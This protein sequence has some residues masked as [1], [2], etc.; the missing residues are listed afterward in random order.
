[1]TASAPQRAASVSKQLAHA[2]AT[3][4]LA[5]MP[6]GVVAEAERAV[7]D[8]FGSALAGAIERPALVCRQVVSALGAS[9]EATVFLAGRA[10][11]A[12]AALAN[13]VAAHILELDDI[14]KASTVHAGAPVIAAAFAVAERER[15]ASPD[16]LLA[17]IVGYEAALRVGEAVNPSHYRFWHPT[18]TAAT[19]G[20]AVAAG[21][22]LHLGP[23]RML[24]ALGTAGTQAA[25]LW[26][27]NADGAMSKPLHAGKA[28]FNGVLAADLAA[29]GFSGATRILEGPRGFFAA[30]S[31]TSD[32]TRITDGLGSRWKIRENCYKVHSCCAHTHAAIDLAIELRT[33]HDYPRQDGVG[34]I[35]DVHVETYGPGFAIVNEPDPGTPAR[36]QFSMTYCVAVGLAE[37]EAGLAQFAESRF[38]TSGVRD[39]AVAALMR[40]TRVTVDDGLTRRYPAAWPAR[41]TVTLDD[42][43]VLRGAADFPRGNPER[44]LSTADLEHKFLDLLGGRFGQNRARSALAAARATVGGATVASAI[45]DHAPWAVHSAW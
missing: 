16:F 37:G 43:T 32:P 40:R 14:H 6:D 21:S 20:A 23:D 1:M 18:G 4:R 22:L 34:R 5:D 8:W 3:A 41:L 35:A 24:D 27:F 19:F 33:R 9:N 12:G 38:D 11:A 29:R 15:A 7:L 2:L 42:G 39:P 45:S 44:A 31:S 36:A 10:S 17:V 26:E 28:A 30:T 25:G 13:G